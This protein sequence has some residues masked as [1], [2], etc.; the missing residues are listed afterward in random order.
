MADV[1]LVAVAQGQQKLPR[2]ALGLR[3][4]EERAAASPQVPVVEQR[5]EVAVL[6]EF[7]HQE[8]GVAPMADRHAQER[9][10]VRV[11]SQLS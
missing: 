6:R 10:D 1:A 3:L 2:Q 5:P 8:H 7:Q 9:H 4:P 11:A